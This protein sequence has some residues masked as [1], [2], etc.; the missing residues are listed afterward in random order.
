MSNQEEIVVSRRNIFLNSED[1]NADINSDK[2][3]NG[4]T[5]TIPLQNLNIIASD[6]QFIRLKLESFMAPNSFDNHS[7]SNQSIYA[8]FGANLLPKAS[9]ATPLPDNELVHS[10]LIMPRYT[11]FQDI[12]TDVTNAIALNFQEAGFSQ[13]DWNYTFNGVWGQGT[14]LYPATLRDGVLPPQAF[15]A[16]PAS[17]PGLPDIPQTY[18]SIGYYSQSGYNGLVGQFTLV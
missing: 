9:D 4:Q 6:N 13:A 10:Y 5:M 12:M 3:Y 8:F 11:T 17:T 7:A 14:A 15:N 2:A 18:D 16:I 1:R